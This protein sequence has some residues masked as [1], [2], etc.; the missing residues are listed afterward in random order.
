MN[1][2]T[3]VGINLGKQTFHLHSQ[4]KPGRELFRKKHLRPQMMRLFANLSAY[5]LVME[6]CAGA[7]FVAR[8][9]YPVLRRTDKKYI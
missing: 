5:T 6:A 9:P 1:D 7:H 2:L 4:D 8:T 3:L